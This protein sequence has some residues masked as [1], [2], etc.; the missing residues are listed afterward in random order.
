MLKKARWL[1]LTVLALAPFSSVQASGT[2]EGAAE[3]HDVRI[4][5]ATLTASGSMGTARLEPVA[6]PDVPEDKAI[7]CYLDVTTTSTIVQC[8]AFNPQFWL[9]CVSTDK[10]F[11]SAVA[12][13]SGDSKITFEVDPR[14]HA[15]CKHLIIDNNSMYQQKAN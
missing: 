6:D 10:N 15:T 1:L 7:G 4:F 8:N 12:A 5:M 2:R 14:D 11:V 13:M 9:G 3:G